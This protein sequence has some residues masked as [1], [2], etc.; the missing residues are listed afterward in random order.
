MLPHCILHRTSGEGICKPDN[1]RQI[2]PVFCVWCPLSHP[3]RAGSISNPSSMSFFCNSIAWCLASSGWPQPRYAS[4][5][6][7]RP[8]RSRRSFGVTTPLD[9]NAITS[10]LRLCPPPRTCKVHT[11]RSSELRETDRSCSTHTPSWVRSTRRPRDTSDQRG[12]ARPHRV[13]C[14]TLDSS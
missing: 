14:C 8:H 4:T 10:Y 2:H 7:S 11:S 6:A 9:L 5:F 3:P 13:A 12:L 1:D